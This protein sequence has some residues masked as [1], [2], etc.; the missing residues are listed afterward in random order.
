MVDI[1]V[2]IIVPVY[3]VEAYLKQCLESIINQTLKEIEIILVDDGS[4]D[5]CPQICDEYS[6]IDSRIK[7]I[8]KINGGY[9][10]AINVGL[11]MASGEFI[12]IVESDDYCAIDM[13][14]KMYNKIKNT[15]AD[16]VICDYY[17]IEKANSF[18]RHYLN[19]NSSEQQYNLKINPSILNNPSYPWK[20][21]YRAKFLEKNNIKMLAD[22]IGAYEDLPWNA[23]ILTYANKI[24]HVDEPLY[25]YRKFSIN[26]STNIGSRKLLNDLKRRIQARDCYITHNLFN[27]EIKKY[28]CLFAICGAFDTFR[29]IAFP[30]KEEYYN[31]MKSFLIETITDN[32]DFKYFPAKWRNRYHYI[33]WMPYKMYYFVPICIN[34][35]K[36]FYQNLV[37]EQGKSR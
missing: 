37:L 3:N 27:G 36:T 5:R 10:S 28:F 6:Q 32:E 7:V 35:L 24:L 12:G 8:H 22:G 20:N 4:P 18:K 23:A 30:Y 29:K 21:L 15:D 34:Y 11:E 9:A 1:R 26:S 33:K 13:Y 2:S 17:S 14:E 19:A 25:Y 16:F 31:A